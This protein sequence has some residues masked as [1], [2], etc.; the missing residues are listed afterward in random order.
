MWICVWVSTYVFIGL[1]P[2][3]AVEFVAGY[4]NDPPSPQLCF[5]AEAQASRQAAVP[6]SVAPHLLH[7][8][9]RMPH[10]TLRNVWASDWGRRGSR[11]MMAELLRIMLFKC[12][13]WVG[14]G[15]QG[16]LLVLFAFGIWETGTEVGKPTRYSAIDQIVP[17]QHNSESSAWH[18]S[19]SLERTLISVSQDV[20]QT[21]W[22]N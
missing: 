16:L 4:S 5:P 21:W 19:S 8:R 15:T 10:P 3:S 13:V 22:L 7:H 6:P 9:Y 1:L 17:A 2:C 11:G 18:V 12:E 20:F 14:R